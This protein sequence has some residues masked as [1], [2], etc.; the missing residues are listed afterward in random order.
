MCPF[1]VK[2]L[3]Q[4]SQIKGRSPVWTRMCIVRWA[5]EGNILLQR[6]QVFLLWLD[7]RELG[8]ICLLLGTPKAK[9]WVVDV[10][11]AETVKQADRQGQG[12]NFLPSMRLT[13]T[14]AGLLI[15]YCHT[16]SYD[17]LIFSLFWKGNNLYTWLPICLPGQ[18]QRT[19]TS[20]LPRK[21]IIS[22]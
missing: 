17:L 19:C 18:Q 5:F 11:G 15:I 3:P 22:F 4:T 10:C 7:G 2:D 8:S 13:E 9:D 21:Q 6:E 14:P 16:C 20:P 12:N 1:C